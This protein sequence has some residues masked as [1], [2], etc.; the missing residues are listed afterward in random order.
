MSPARNGTSASSSFALTRRTKSV[1]AA[2]ISPALASV[3]RTLAAVRAE[4]RAPGGGDFS[5]TR[6]PVELLLI[7]HADHAKILRDET[8]LLAV[9]DFLEELLGH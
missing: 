4:H 1:S 3:V 9:E 2:T 6:V 7:P 8:S 5:R